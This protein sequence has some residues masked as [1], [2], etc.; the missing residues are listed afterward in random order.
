MRW[1]IKAWRIGANIEAWLKIKTEGEI[2]RHLWSRGFIIENYKK[3]IEDFSGIN[4]SI[5]CETIESIISIEIKSDNWKKQTNKSP[6]P[7]IVFLIEDYFKIESLFWFY[8]ETLN[9]TEILSIKNNNRSIE[10][11]K[12]ISRIKELSF[13][14]NFKKPTLELLS[15]SASFNIDFYSGTRSTFQDHI[16]FWISFL[17]WVSQSEFEYTNL[18]YILTVKKFHPDNGSC[19][20]VRIDQINNEIN[21]SNS[22]IEWFNENQIQEIYLMRKSFDNKVILFLFEEK[23]L[24]YHCWTDE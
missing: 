5:D 23:Y 3:E 20:P 12:I 13:D 14:Q 1:I 4:F 15:N 11:L 7:A 19:I 8:L 10:P 17:G 6:L 9:E 2:R 24:I 21:Y 18:N 22:K 16:D